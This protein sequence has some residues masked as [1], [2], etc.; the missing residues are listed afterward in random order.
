[1]ISYDVNMIKITFSIIYINIEGIKNDSLDLL[2]KPNYCV[3]SVTVEEEDT[4][5]VVP[6][7]LPAQV[8]M[9]VVAVSPN[10]MLKLSAVPQQVL[11]PQ[12]CRMPVDMEAAVV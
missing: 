6:V 11:S 8:R 10:P 9:A 2:Q 3:Q 7:V 12:H 1:M 4:P 5:P